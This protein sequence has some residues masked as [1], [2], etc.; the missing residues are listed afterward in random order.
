[1]TQIKRSGILMYFDMK[2]VLE[3]LSDHE[4]KELLLAILDYGENGVVPEFHSATLACFWPLLASRMDA[5]RERYP[6]QGG[7]QP[8]RRPRTL[9]RPHDGGHGDRGGMPVYAN[10]CYIK[11]KKKEKRRYSEKKHP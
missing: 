11:E 1:M 3:R 9:G 10:G 4:V 2:P 5:D 8:P 6:A 7:I